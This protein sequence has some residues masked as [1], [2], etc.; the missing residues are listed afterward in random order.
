MS[1]GEEQIE[2]LKYMFQSNTNRDIRVEIIDNLI[3]FGNTGFNAIYEL[4]KTTDNS[5]LL[6]YGLEQIR[7]NKE[8]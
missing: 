6:M 4:L 1:N 7:K 5:E 8:S 3:K 2:N